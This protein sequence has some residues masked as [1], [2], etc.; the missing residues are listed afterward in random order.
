MS[1]KYNGKKYD[2]DEIPKILQK[3][4]NKNK[5]KKVTVLRVILIILLILIIM[6]IAVIGAA[7]W[8]INDKIGMM[9]QV[10]INEEELGIT[11]E[12]EESL[13]GYR[14]IA[15]FG[16]DSRADDY[17]KGNRS[18][19]IIIASINNKTK[20][21]RLI[22]VYRDTYV[23]IEGHGLDK[24]THA[25]SYGEAQL[26]LNTLNTNLDLNIKEFVTVN[27]DSVSDAVDAL[28][29]VTIDITNEELKYINDY[30]DATAASTK[31]KSKHITKAGRQTLDGVQAVAYSR[32]R[33]TSGG[34][35]K[36]TE[37]M[38]DVIEAMLAKLKTKNVGEINKLAN[39]ILPKIYTNLDTGDVLSVAT[40]VMNYKITKSIGW[41]YETKGIT[42][43]RWY[44]IPVTLESNVKKLHEE[45]FD[46]KDYVVPNDVKNISNSI[47]KKTGYK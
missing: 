12:T 42:L 21:V 27:F 4:K 8:Y 7:Y 26:A 23:K 19:C 9:Q 20:E 37:R 16:V 33:Y 18:D 2:E 17:G 24:I 6:A 30:I 46:E 11:T 25:Y 3:G 22:S 47:I 43:D 34:D 45:L 10:E 38:R 28:G 40:D 41:P 35:Y 44:G 5:S 15:L 13:S 29:G 36:R 39:Q 32:I 1:K 31:K 14:N